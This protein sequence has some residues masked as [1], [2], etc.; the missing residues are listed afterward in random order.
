[1]LDYPEDG[2]TEQP[3]QLLY[4][5]WINTKGKFLFI[6]ILFI[7]KLYEIPNF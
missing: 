7:E 2:C 1:M 5:V 3:N 6:V 4:I